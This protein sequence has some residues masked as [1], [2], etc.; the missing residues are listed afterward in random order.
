MKVPYLGTYFSLDSIVTRRGKCL[1]I[2]M[3]ITMKSYFLN[4]FFVL[5]T[6]GVPFKCFTS[7]T[8]EINIFKIKKYKL[9]KKIFNILHKQT[10]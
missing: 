4:R 3:E 6:L 5:T 2:F 7:K 1:R 8:R 10:S 9:I